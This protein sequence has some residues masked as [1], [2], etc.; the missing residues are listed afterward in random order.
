MVFAQR[1]M[2]ERSVVRFL[3][4]IGKLSAMVGYA[5]RIHAVHVSLNRWL[6]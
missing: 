5:H 1:V 2:L 3:F 6:C 4:N